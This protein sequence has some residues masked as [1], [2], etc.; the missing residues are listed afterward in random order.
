MKDYLSLSRIEQQTFPGAKISYS[1]PPML[2]NSDSLWMT[3]TDGTWLAGTFAPGSDSNDLCIIHFYS[4]GETLKTA[5]LTINS[6]RDLGASVLCFD[7]RGFGASGGRPDETG[8]YSDALFAYDW[9]AEN[10][11]KLR[12]I[13]SGRSL[14]AAVATFLAKERNVD[15]LLLFSPMTNVVDII[16]YIFP[17]DEIVIEDA[18]PFRFDTMSLI[19]D[20]SCPVFLAHGRSDSVA[21]YA[22][23]RIIEL[24]IKTEVTRHDI[25]GAGHNDLIAVGGDELWECI[26]RFLDKLRGRRKRASV[27]GSSYPG[28]S[29]RRN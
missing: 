6:F 27:N 19:E 4:S 26:D 20:I 11:P 13:V 24:S 21:P 1:E 14:G 22:M 7:Y 2:V 5:E 12:P 15:G 17:P 10:H 23:S 29:Y 3:S 25:L 9:L 8:F 28:A 18:L 16:K